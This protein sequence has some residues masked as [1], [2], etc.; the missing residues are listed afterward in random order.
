M[1][2]QDKTWIHGRFSKRF[3]RFSGPTH[4]CMILIAAGG[5]P[6]MA[7]SQSEAP[8]QAATT[9]PAS[10]S[11]QPTQSAASN[12]KQSSGDFVDLDLEQLMQI[13][14]TSVA[15]INQTL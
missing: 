5:L 2:A 3:R 4:A 13:E 12:P 1:P 9:Q 7:L 14:V 15:G 6:R 10:P 8:N 11:T